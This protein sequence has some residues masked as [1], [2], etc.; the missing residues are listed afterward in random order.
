MGRSVTKLVI[1]F[2]VVFGGFSLPFS[3]RAQALIPFELQWKKGMLILTSGDTLYGQASLTLPNDIVKL[4]NETGETNTFLPN[5][6]RFLAVKEPFNQIP[7][8]RSGDLLLNERDYA[9]YNWNRDNEY[10]TYRAPALFVV[11]IPG[12]NALLLREQKEQQQTATTGSMAA[13]VAGQGL[14][15]AGANAV[16][17]R[18]YLSINGQEPKWLRNPK[19]DLLKHFP[20]KKKQIEK[21]A[22]TQG[23]YFHRLDH[24]AR[25]VAYI[26]TL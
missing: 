21:F 1:Y 14:E 2:I 11:V 23:I 26:N 18:F 22:Q 25:I 17:E 5:Q 12:K 19:K 3:G 7:Y 4:K 16:A 6:I 20:E 15:A 24:L 8:R 13:Y 10:S 9:Q